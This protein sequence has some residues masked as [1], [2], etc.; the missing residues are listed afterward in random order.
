MTDCSKHLILDTA[1]IK[2]ALIALNNLANDSLTLFVVNTSSV[3]F[4]TLTD[5]DIRRKLIDGCRLDC[6][7]SM[8]M[9][10]DF[11]YLKEGDIDVIFV[12]GLK[13]KNIT[14]IPVLDSNKR[15]LE[16]YDLKK[17]RSILPV[18]VVLMAGGK[19]ERLRPLTEKMPKPLLP[20]GGKPIIDHNIDSLIDFGVKNIYVTVNYLKEQLISHFGLPFKGIQIKCISEPSFLGTMG[21]IKFVSSFANDYI[22][23]MNSDLFTNINYEDLFL[24]FREHDADMSVVAVPY[25][26]SIPYGIFDLDGREIKGVKEKPIFNYYANAGIYLFKRE[27]LN[28]IPDNEF[29]NA[30]DLIDSL[31]QNGHKVIRYPL[32][33]YWIDIGKHED[34]RKAQDLVKHL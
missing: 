31:V 23:V 2:E 3:M 16:I 6:P 11:N 30:T 10:R 22:L 14:L 17:K 27:H 33:G 15:I 5:G 1:S 24:H 20:V 18:D 25:T 12:K 7:V 8:V 26:I 29:F 9:N 32:T 4:G 28:L 21:S 13:K 34:Y 19:G